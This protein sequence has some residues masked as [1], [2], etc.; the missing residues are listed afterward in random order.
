MKEIISKEELNK[1]MALKGEARG[2]A[3]KSHG[4]FILKEKGEAGLRKLEQAMEDLGCSVNHKELESMKFYPIY[5]EVVALVVIKQLFNFEDEK[6]REMGEFASKISLI[7]KLFIKYFISIKTM[8]GQVPNIW[9]KY[10]TIGNIKV[11]ELDMV[12]NRLILRLE[13]FDLHSLHCLHLEGY[14]SSVVKMTVKN[15]V[16]CLETRCVHRGDRYHEFLLKW[17]D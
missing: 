4:E 12:G 15:P 8:V 1:L 13:D 14:F 10:Y 5:L 3:I 11:I 17:E 16:T 2:L 9:E 7:L 6:F